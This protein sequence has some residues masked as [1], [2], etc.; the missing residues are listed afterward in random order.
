MAH[1]SRRSEK[2]EERGLRIYAHFAAGAAAFI[3]THL[4][5]VLVDM[6]LPM[7][8]YSIFAALPSV[9]LFAKSNDCP[10]DT[11]NKKTL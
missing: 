8:P 1:V 7:A 4:A 9:G 10:I 5:A 2:Q 6:A 3:S 11:D